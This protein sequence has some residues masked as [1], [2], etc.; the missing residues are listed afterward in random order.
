ML[1]K[2]FFKFMLPT[3]SKLH[4]QNILDVLDS[5]LD[6]KTQ[7]Y[8]IKTDRISD[9]IIED[10]RINITLN[11]HHDELEIYE[12]IQMDVERLIKTLPE[13][14][15]SKMK[16]FVIMTTHKKTLDPPPEKPL[17]K[18]QFDLSEI[19]NII[20]VASGKGG[21]GKSTT[22]VNLAYALKDKGL[23]VGILDADIYGPS[24][25]KMFNISARPESDENNHMIPIIKNDIQ[26]ISMGFL[27]GE[28]TPVIWRGP[29]VQKAITQFLSQVRWYNLDVLLIDMPPGTGDI[30]L[31]LVKKAHIKGAVIV[32][33]P[34]DIA[35]IDAKKAIAMFKK[36]H[37]P[38]LGLV[39]NMSYFTCPHC[40]GR[41]EIFSH[42][43]AH[44]T[45]DS[46]KI[47]FLAEVPLRLEIRQ[48]TDSGQQEK[49]V[50]DI[51]IG[52]PYRQAAKSLMLNMSLR[53]NIPPNAE[54]S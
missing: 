15:S 49:L 41:S 10:R 38:I 42:G 37:T 9:I 43:G 13:V 33:T 5:L 18:G 25:P 1:K 54:S 50:R 16:V 12:K 20:A 36:V 4:P 26:L 39:E 22:T 52:Y 30:H 2:D 53:N 11:V 3:K 14:K 6:P 31:T 44:D 29:M 32:S 47:P 40:K 17:S 27:I 48:Q 51:D 7:K 34:Q 35:L 45:A 8:L 24:I 21:V 28:N 19:K 23:R 46:L